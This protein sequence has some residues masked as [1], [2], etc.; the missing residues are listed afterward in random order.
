MSLSSSEPT[1]SE[2]T[3]MT[4]MKI[5]L[6]FALALWLL[7]APTIAAAQA[8]VFVVRHAERADTSADSLLSAEGQARASRLAAML[9]DAGITQI[10]T[11]NL[12][13]TVQTAAPLADALRLTA[14]ELPTTALD[15]LVSRLQAATSRDRVLVVGHSNTVPEILKRLGI[16]E[17]ITIA[18]TEYD[19][20]FVAIPQKGSPP[21]F[22]RLRY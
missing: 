3:T 19:N 17:P 22:I 10:Y 21:L 13:R 4:S 15:A 2:I 6:T 1:A 16:A 20:L 8:A 5:A 9:K 12:R 18:D 7:A 14:T 11:T